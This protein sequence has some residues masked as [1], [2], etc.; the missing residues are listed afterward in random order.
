MKGILI[1]MAIGWLLLGGFALGNMF[2]FIKSNT[3]LQ[4]YTLLG[5]VLISALSTGIS[6][7]IAYLVYLWGKEESQNAH[8]KEMDAQR[9]QQTTIQDLTTAKK[10]IAESESLLD[11]IKAKKEMQAEVLQEL[12]N[13]L[14]A[15][16][17]ELEKNDPK[18][19]T[20]TS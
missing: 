9:N 17:A 11:K 10:L 7:W 13:G 14:Q 1:F 15:F 19:K 8:Y 16:K 3:N 4:G 12:E 5:Y 18:S 6:A 20:K 2:W